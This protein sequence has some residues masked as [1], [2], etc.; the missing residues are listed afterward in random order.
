MSGVVEFSGKADISTGDIL[1]CSFSFNNLSGSSE[2][3]AFTLNGSIS[4][5]ITVSPNRVTMNMLLQITST[6]KV[7]WI[8]DYEMTVTDGADYVTFEASGYY[9]DPDYGYGNLSTDTPIVT[10]NDSSWPFDGVL[11]ITGDTG[12]A[13]GSTKA[14]L[15]AISSSTYQLAADTNGDGSFDWDSGV[16]Y[17]SEDRGDQDT[18]PPTIPTGLTAVTASHDTIDISWNA[19]SDNFGVAGYKIYRDDVE[20][21]TVTVNQSNAALRF[22][23][24]IV[25]QPNTLAAGATNQGLRYSTAVQPGADEQSIHLLAKAIRSSYRDT[26]LTPQ[27]EYCYTVSAYDAA[28]N[29]SDQCTAECATTSSQVDDRDPTAPTDLEV[30]ATSSTTIQLTWEA[31][32]DNVGVEGYRIYRDGTEIDTTPNTQYSDTGLSAD[33]RYCYTVAAY[34]AAG[35]QSGTS[36]Q[37]CDTTTDGCG[38]GLPLTISDLDFPD[39]V[40]SETTQSGSAAYQGSFGD[41]DNPLVITLMMTDDTDYYSASLSSRPVTRDCRIV[42]PVWIP[43]GLSGTGTTYFRLVDYDEN[44]GLRENF[45]NNSVANQ[46]SQDVTIFNADTIAPSAPLDLS[47]TAISNNQID[48][49]WEAAIDDVGVEGYRIYRDGTEIDTTPST[50][51]SDTGLSADTRYCYTVAAYDAAGNQSDNSNQECDTTTDGCGTGL[52]LAIS[53]LDFPDSVPSET[54]PSGSVAYQGSFDDIDNPLFII[55]TSVYYSAALIPGPTASNCRITFPVWIPDGLS[56]TET[57]YFRLVDYDENLGLRENFENNS[58]ANQLS[59]AV[60]IN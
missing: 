12:D 54:T 37:E 56:G 33:T 32:E 23:V 59:K 3:D 47:V 1:T 2:S 25:M 44:L 9:Y 42:F 15:T 40:A 6:G 20:L 39:S 26:G 38:T 8:K 46:L 50:Q 48:L 28:G 13:G 35:N 43:D 18:Q 57:I 21:G 51:Y 22:S 16:L 7:Y 36:N 4:Y 45:E 27:T 5:D 52:P 58:V 11:V 30:E 34:D 31:A 19:C 14:R 17:W 53:D 24:E 29:M 49:N 55:R 60:T 10:P 41:I